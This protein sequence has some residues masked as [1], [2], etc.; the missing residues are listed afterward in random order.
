VGLLLGLEGRRLWAFL[1]PEKLSDVWLLPRR[2]A[3]VALAP[4]ST[5]DGRELVNDER[6]DGRELVNDER[7][8]QRDMD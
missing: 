2:Q 5:T 7:C 6:C 4:T 8:D 3:T 1:R